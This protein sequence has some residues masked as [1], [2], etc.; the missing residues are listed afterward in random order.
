MTLFFSNQFTNCNQ[1][2]QLQQFP[3]AERETFSNH[4]FQNI[5]VPVNTT[6]RAA[7]GK[8]K[9]YRDRGLLENP[10]VDD[11][12]QDGKFKVPTLRN[13][14]LTAPYMHNGVFSELRTVM[15]FYNKYLARGSR[16]QINPE[17]GEAWGEPETAAN[18]AHDKLE[19][20]RALDDRGVDAL[21]AFMRM[22]TDQRYEAL[23]EFDAQGAD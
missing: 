5:G 7:N 12:E 20:G 2:H 1:C 3:E 18:I 10:A 13:V 22:L 21:V 6:L 9:T 16:A 4:T 8:G 15:L 19:A 14:A 23:L 11:P 17:T